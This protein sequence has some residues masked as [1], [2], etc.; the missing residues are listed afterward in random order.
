MQYTVL[1]HSCPTGIY[2]ALTPAVPGC[3]GK[4]GT[5]D[6]A[7]EQLRNTLYDWLS[8]TEITSIDV[9]FPK[10][11]RDTQNPW[12]TTAGM[13]ADDPTLEPM[14]REIYSGAFISGLY[15]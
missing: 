15:K 12:I 9:D 1:L 11:E 13:F 7:L 10:S 4:G 14:V 5:R 6:E 8:R 2:E 3:V